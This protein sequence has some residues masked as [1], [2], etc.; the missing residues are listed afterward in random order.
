MFQN[1]HDKCSTYSKSSYEVYASSTFSSSQK[2]T[3]SELSDNTVPTTPSTLTK[4]N[5]KLEFHVPQ[6]GNFN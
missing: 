5:T 6:R 1:I 4:E 3:T 2:L